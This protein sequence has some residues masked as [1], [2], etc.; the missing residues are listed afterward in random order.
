MKIICHRGLWEHN[1]EKNSKVAFL[2]GYEFGFGT[3]TDIRDLNG[4]VVISHDPPHSLCLRFS[5]YLDITP[6]DV[7]IALNVKSDGIAMTVGQILKEKRHSN[8]F[9]FDM[10][11]PDLFSYRKL[12][13]PFAVRV[14][15]FEPFKSGLELDAKYIWLD[16]LDSLWYSTQ[17]LESLLNTGKKIVIVSEELH[18]R[19]HNEQ[20]S[21]IKKLRDQ[22]QIVLCTDFPLDAVAYFGCGIGKD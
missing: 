8:L 4:E 9:F 20:W 3:E 18:G 16:C 13:L 19:N 6:K 15:E 14:S 1:S 2:R 7:L 22:E 10:S 21:Q 17:Q 11:I 5:D 12:Q